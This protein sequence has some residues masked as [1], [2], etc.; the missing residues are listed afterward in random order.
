M[1]AGAEWGLAEVQAPWGWQRGVSTWM[2]QVGVKVQPQ[3]P[4]GCA[5]SQPLGALVSSLL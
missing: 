5:M 4:A 2:G 1:A 3:P